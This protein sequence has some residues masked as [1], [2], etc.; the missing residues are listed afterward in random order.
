VS[1]GHR[2]CEVLFATGKRAEAIELCS[3]ILYNVK[4]V[5]GAIDTTTVLSYNLLSAMY[6]AAGS[7]DKAMELHVE[8]LRET[9]APENED[10][11]VSVASGVILQQL[12]LLKRSYQ[13]LGR[14]IQNPEEYLK[15]WDGFE[16]LFDP[17]DDLWKGIDHIKS[18]TPKATGIQVNEGIGMWKAPGNWCF[19]LTDEEKKTRGRH[20]CHLRSEDDD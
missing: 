16:E 12:K 19:L 4:R 20:A 2:L 9:L 14:W 10:E 6:T 18:W 15:L 8:L 3:D 5:W 7:Y 17:T 1:I 11:L 13:R